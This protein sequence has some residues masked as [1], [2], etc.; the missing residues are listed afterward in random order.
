MIRVDILNVKGYSMVIS[1]RISWNSLS[2][3]MPLVWRV[4]GD[5]FCSFPVSCF[6][7]GR[8]L[9][10]AREDLVTTRVQPQ[11]SH[12]GSFLFESRCGILVEF[13]CCCSFRTCPLGFLRFAL[14]SVLWA[15]FCVSTYLR[16]R[17]TPTGQR[18]A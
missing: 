14:P 8:P 11:S 6:W 12:T 17:K 16:Q 1:K 18:G 13:S 9:D 5:P 10:C 15:S 2:L 4:T 7:R 3:W